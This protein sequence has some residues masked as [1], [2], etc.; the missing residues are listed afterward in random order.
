MAS[1]TLSG[2][3]E[4]HEGM[5]TASDGLIEGSASIS[6]IFTNVTLEPS[7]RVIKAAAG[8]KVSVTV[9]ARLSYNDEY[10]S[11]LKVKW[12]Q[13]NVIGETSA[14]FSIE[15]PSSPA[16]ETF[17]LIDFI[18][19]E[20]VN[21]SLIP[22]TV[23]L[24]L[25]S[26]SGAKQKGDE[27]WTQSGSTMVIRLKARYAYCDDPLTTIA[28]TDGGSTKHADANGYV[29]FSYVNVDKKLQ[30]SF[31]AV[32]GEYA[33][34]RRINVTLV[35][36]RIR[37]EVTPNATLFNGVWYAC[38]DANVSVRIN[39]I[40]AHDGMP[41]SNSSVTYLDI[42][43]KM[44]EDGV[45]VLNLSG[46]DKRYEGSVNV[47]DGIVNGN[48]KLTFV[49]TG[50]ALE[51]SSSVVEGFP[52]DDALL[53]V[54]ARL[55]CNGEY[56][57]GLKVRWVENDTV[58]ET[59]ANFILRVPK[60]G[61]TNATFMLEG[62]LACYRKL[63][64]KVVAV[65]A[66]LMAKVNGTL[67]DGKYWIQSGS[68]ATVRV[69]LRVSLNISTSDMRIVDSY[70]NEALTDSNGTATF[71]YRMNDKTVTINYTLFNNRG[72]P[73]GRMNITLVFSRIIIKI[74]EVKNSVFFAGTYYVSDGG[75][76]RIL[77]MATYSHDG[78]LVIGARVSF[79]TKSSET[80]SNGSA[81]ISLS[82]SDRE[83]D[84]LMKVEDGIV[85]GDIP[86]RIVFTDVK[87]ETSSQVL[88]GEPG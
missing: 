70:G 57:S 75:N 17:V 26:I 29:E 71:H 40:Y 78:S 27:Y 51:P 66:S 85:K 8:A 69:K 39:A 10:L 77:V 16:D 59:P 60:K 30:P 38:N 32:D 76:A 72:D 19:C 50:V 55:T 5:I 64:V 28:I 88:A 45:A 15:M 41:A 82:D 25:E 79:F 42:S 9:Y 33:L 47:S 22:K 37:L 83:Y 31:L 4:E 18:P 54:K 81:V 58:R 6:L 43:T 20:P 62:F 14:P 65:N 3:D 53:V 67:R 56:L 61:S 35:F 44:D 24:S 84:G 34:S 11:G 49:F 46:S 74:T 87:L 12:V 86:L 21:V 7:Q 80:D 48:E 23:E 68:T 13:G 1:F 63:V 2:N 36:T 52:E 73:I